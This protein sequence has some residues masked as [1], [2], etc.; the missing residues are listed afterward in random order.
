MKIIN[1]FVFYAL[2][3]ASTALA[4]ILSPV[5]SNYKL[6]QE[7]V[8]KGDDVTLIFTLNIDKHWHVYSTIQNYE[9][10][11]MPT[12]FE[13]EPDSSYKLLG[14]VMPVGSKKEHEPVFDVDVNYFEK[15]A[16]FR[17]RIKICS[18]NPIIRGSYEYQVCSV[19]DGKCILKTADF[20]FKIKTIK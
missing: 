18:E 1:L 17:Q 2:F 19:Q 16:E 15:I 14:E 11:P 8:K 13:F 5:Q 4:Q 20:E 3:S 10:G 9:L 6:S 12:V 7:H